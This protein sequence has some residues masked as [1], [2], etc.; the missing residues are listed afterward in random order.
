MQYPGSS[1][2][3]VQGQHSSSSETALDALALYQ[4]SSDHDK[5]VDFNAICSALEADAPFFQVST[6]TMKK[7]FRDDQLVPLVDDLMHDDIRVVTKSAKVLHELAYGCEAIS[8]M[9]RIRMLSTPNALQSICHVSKWAWLLPFAALHRGEGDRLNG[10][11]KY[12]V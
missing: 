5:V 10:I 7:S 1:I 4:E 9:I 2:G 11:I 6:I 8:A 3:Q 12:T